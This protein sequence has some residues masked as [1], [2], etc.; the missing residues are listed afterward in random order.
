[1]EAESSGASIA[2]GIRQ[3]PAIRKTSSLQL[4]VFFETVCQH[5]RDSSSLI[6]WLIC[7]DPSTGQ[8]DSR[9]APTSEC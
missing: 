6:D 3:S 4:R 2:N 7:A 8:N 9:P 5:D 1:M